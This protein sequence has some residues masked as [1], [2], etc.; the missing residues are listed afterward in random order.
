[1]MAVVVV[2]VVV[3]AAVVIDG[4]Q[5]CLNIIRFHDFSSSLSQVKQLYLSSNMLGT[6]LT[7]ADSHSQMPNFVVTYF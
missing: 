7:I 2:V 3:A 1:M 4:C 6:I 5:K